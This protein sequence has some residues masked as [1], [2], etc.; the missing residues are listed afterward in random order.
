MRRAFRTTALCLLTTLVAC[1]SKSS[2]GGPAVSAAARQEAEAF[3]TQTCVPCHGSTGHGDGPGS[4]ALQ[5]KP[6]SFADAS[7]QDQVSDEQ[8][9]KTI[10]LGGAA[11][12]KSP[13]MP[14]QPQLKE[15]TELLAALVAKIRAYRGK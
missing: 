11:V 15:K 10:T 4:G 12:G 2:T 9:V 14:A 7:W 13:V 1:G 8:I 6:R 3:F 5:P